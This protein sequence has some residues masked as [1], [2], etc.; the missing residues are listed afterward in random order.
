[1]SENGK[2]A[3]ETA[4]QVAAEVVAPKQWLHPDALTPRDYLRGKLAL[5]DVLAERGHE[6]PYD[7]LGTDEMYTW[8]IWAL[9][10]RADVSFTWDAALDTPFYEFQMGGDRPPPPPAGP[11]S[12]SGSKPGRSAVSR[13]KPELPSVESVSSSGSSSA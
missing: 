13:A 10:S 2:V 11:P 12:L 6:S 1:M 9:R 5:K 4:E 3:A 8:L 7:F